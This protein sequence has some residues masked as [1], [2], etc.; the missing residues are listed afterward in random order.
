MAF[1]AL[2]SK[3]W[4]FS[5]VLLVR[6]SHPEVF[7]KK[8]VLRNFAKFTGRQLCESRFFNKIAG[9]VP[10]TLSQVFSCEFIE[11]SK[12]TFFTENHRVTTSDCY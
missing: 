1:Y 11:I 6:N 4:L 12:T 8:D 9:V 3:S 10:E 7:C 2:I 5:D